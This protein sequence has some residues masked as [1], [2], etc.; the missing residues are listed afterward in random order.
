MPASA[1]WEVTN[2]PKITVKTVHSARVDVGI[3]PYSEI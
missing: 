1:L 2:S 3:D